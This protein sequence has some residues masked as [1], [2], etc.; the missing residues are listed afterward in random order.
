[1]LQVDVILD[2]FELCI[3]RRNLEQRDL[4][5]AVFKIVT[6]YGKYI[7]LGPK[8]YFLLKLIIIKVHIIVYHSNIMQILE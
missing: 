1:M 3:P 6:F 4:E 7:F 5:N 2:L 8:K